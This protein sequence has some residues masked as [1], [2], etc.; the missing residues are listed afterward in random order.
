MCPEVLDLG[1]YPLPP[2]LC[3]PMPIFIS[4]EDDAAH[5]RQI[6]SGKFTL[7]TLENG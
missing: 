6:L 7:Q 5:N 4:N 1:P 3:E 2:E